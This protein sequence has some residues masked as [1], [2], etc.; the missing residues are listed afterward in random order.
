M[1]RLSKIA[2]P[3]HSVL[4][5]YLAPFI[6]VAAALTLTI[7]ARSLLVSASY[8]LFL[9]AVMFSSW[10]GGLTPG[11]IAILFSLL[12]L[13]RY[14]ASPELSRQLSQDDIVHL[15]MFLFVA[16]IINHLNRARNRA[17][18]SLMASHQELQAQVN[19]RTADLQHANDTLRRLSAQLMRLQDEERRHMARL[20]H[21]T[22]AQTLAALKMDLSLVKRRTKPNNIEANEALGEAAALADQCIREVR[23]L[24]Y[25][26]HPPLL[27]EAGLSSA[28]Q[29]YATGF[30]QRSGIQVKL[31][32]PADL[33]RLPQIVEV[34][35][36]R[37]VQECLTNIH[38]HSGSGD[39]NISVSDTGGTLVVSV[40]DHGHGM[41]Q[42][43]DRGRRDHMGVGIMG[44]RERVEQL[45]G[46]IEIQSGRG[47]TT[48]M[49]TLPY[50]K[51]PA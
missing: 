38:R 35:V 33:G 49:A 1:A 11:L 28:L 5:R 24:S 19:E 46:H 15:S 42:V 12:A 18:S 34:A 4:F 13:D 50:E 36:F 14:I 3:Q 22:V 48:V 31:E 41:A 16:G 7:S 26:L 29:W 27:D 30:E 17:E 32:L 23:T 40:S 51:M 6:T 43:T 2:D 45:G 25:L 21:E 9:A 47:G 44:M 20:L 10:F 39:A 8:A 37:I